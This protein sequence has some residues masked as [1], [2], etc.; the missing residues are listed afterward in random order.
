MS[1]VEE[2]RFREDLLFRLNAFT[3]T[4]P[5]LRDR[6][7][8][9]LILARSLLPVRS[10]EERLTPFQRRSGAGSCRRS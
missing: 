10:I 8:D 9:A 2:G 4:I 1:R 7:Q 6:D 5:A 3:V